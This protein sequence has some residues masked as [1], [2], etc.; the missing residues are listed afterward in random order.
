MKLTPNEKGK[1]ILVDKNG[2]KAV[3]DYAVDANEAL[4]SKDE[5]GEP[6]YALP[7]V[8]PKTKEPV[9]DKKTEF[10]D[11]SKRAT[12]RVKKEEEK[13]EVEVEDLIPAEKI[14]EEE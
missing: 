6:R 9:S 10:F 5:N 7:G 3:F 2:E 1:F 12:K 11:G 4:N 13:A 14:A 8:I